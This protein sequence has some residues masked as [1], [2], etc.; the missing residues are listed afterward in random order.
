MEAFTFQQWVVVVLVLIAGW[1]LGLLS[2]S[3]R[4]RREA[5]VERERRVEA[6]RNLAAARERNV[7]ADRHAHPIGAGAAGAVGAAARGHRDDLSRIN[8]VGPLGESR[9]NE[10]GVH[11]YA[12]IAALSDSDAH[13]LETRLGKDQGTIAREA[14]RDQASMLAAGRVDEH[15]QR[16]GAA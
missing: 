6:E 12:Q 3:G 2:Q 14:W 9:L 1:L 10:A 11:S 16:Y 5:G 8:G 4:W 13:V 15:R 7:D